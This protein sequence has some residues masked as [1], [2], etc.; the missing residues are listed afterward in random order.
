MTTSTVNIELSHKTCWSTIGRKCKQ[1]HFVADSSGKSHI[2][3]AKQKPTAF[4]TIYIVLNTP[5]Y[6]SYCSMFDKAVD[7]CQ[8][9]L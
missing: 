3:A 2:L 9:D 6:C 7:E 5:F 4:Q 8:N 1:G